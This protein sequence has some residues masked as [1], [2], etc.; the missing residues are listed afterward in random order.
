MAFLA[1]ILALP[2]R[3]PVMGAEFLH[4]LILGIEIQL[5]VGDILV[6]P[7]AKCPV[8]VSTESILGVIG[9]AVVSAKLLRLGDQRM[10]GCRRSGG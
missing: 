10:V 8:G 3:Q 7:P 9:A 5:R 2:E 6:T 4:A 1:P